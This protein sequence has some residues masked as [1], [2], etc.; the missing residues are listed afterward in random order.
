MQQQDLLR[1]GRAG[2]ELVDADL[3]GKDRAGPVGLAMCAGRAQGWGG[4]RSA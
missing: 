2:D 3:A 1:C 4:G